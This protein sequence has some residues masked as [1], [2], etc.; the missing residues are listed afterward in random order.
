MAETVMRESA[1]N[2]AAHGRN[3]LGGRYGR[4]ELGGQQIADIGWEDSSQWR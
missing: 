4:N 2:T 1:G 3:K